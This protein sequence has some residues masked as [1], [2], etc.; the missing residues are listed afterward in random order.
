MERFWSF[1]LS[2]TEKDPGAG[3]L[4][5]PRHTLHPVLFLVSCWKAIRLALP[6]ASM[7]IGMN[8][9]FRLPD[10]PKAHCDCKQLSPWPHWCTIDQC[11]LQLF[12]SGVLIDCFQAPFML[13]Y[14]CIEGRIL[15]KLQAGVMELSKPF[16]NET[17]PRPSVWVS[18]N[19]FQ[20][21]SSNR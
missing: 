8:L 10:H 2:P 14:C 15:Q 11:M 1:P 17:K 7:W 13:C 16:G 18:I 4:S 3:A 19:Y 21:Q 20:I 6:F 5:W 9:P 12:D